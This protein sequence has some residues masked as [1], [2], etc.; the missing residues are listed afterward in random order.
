MIQSFKDQLTAMIREYDY[1]EVTDIYLSL[2]DAMK[3]AATRRLW[4][5]QTK[6][7]YTVIIWNG[8]GEDPRYRKK[9]TQMPVKPG[10]FKKLLEYFA[11]KWGKAREYF[12]RDI[13]GLPVLEC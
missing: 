5:F 6:L 13:R 4:I 7:N 8:K 11:G 3:F 2:P 12:T 1:V 10:W 9:D